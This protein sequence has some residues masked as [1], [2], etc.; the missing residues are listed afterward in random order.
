MT[1]SPFIII[2]LFSN[3]VLVKQISKYLNTGG[4]NTVGLS[5]QGCVVQNSLLSQ[6]ES[7]K[8]NGVQEEKNQR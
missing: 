3:R 5:S 4:Y 1:L 2:H 7:R 8:S 6:Q